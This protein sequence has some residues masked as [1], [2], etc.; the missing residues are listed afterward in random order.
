[1]AVDCRSS[2]TNGIMKFIPLHDDRT[3][4]I[5]F[6]WW[7]VYYWTPVQSD[8]SNRNKEYENGVTP[9][10]LYPYEEVDAEVY[11]PRTSLTGVV[12]KSG[13]LLRSLMI[14]TGQIPTPYYDADFHGNAR[15]LWCF[16]LSYCA[17]GSAFGE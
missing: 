13:S 16:L 11:V 15:L 9:L 4:Q 10:G 3:R 2:D 1:M 8:L 14:R 5:G 7:N 17:V 6:S 12:L